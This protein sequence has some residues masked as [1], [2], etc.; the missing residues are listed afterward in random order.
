MEIGDLV[1]SEIM[2]LYP[3]SLQERCV[4]YYGDHDRW[5]RTNTGSSTTA[6]TTTTG[7]PA[8]TTASA[9]D[10]SAADDGTANDG[11]ANDGTTCRY[12]GNVCKPAGKCT[13]GSVPKFTGDMNGVFP[14]EI[15]ILL[16][17]Y[18]WK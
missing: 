1:D 13:A 6:C 11:A 15:L 10:K 16:W 3:V 18:H 17:M 8:S 7:K 4:K 12:V 2:Q 9:N 5:K 14:K